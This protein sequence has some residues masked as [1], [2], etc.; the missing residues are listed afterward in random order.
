MNETGKLTHAEIDEILAKI[1][2]HASKIN[3]TRDFKIGLLHSVH[4]SRI[5]FAESYIN[6]LKGQ[7]LSAEQ[8][9]RLDALKRK[10]Y[11][12]PE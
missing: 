11:I 10:L 5:R 4:N 12:P 9:E 7:V 2:A 6:S 3:F 1:E 8:S